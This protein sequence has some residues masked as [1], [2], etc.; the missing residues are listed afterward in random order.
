MI[1]SRS[2]RLLATLVVG[3]AVLLAGC[4]SS[5]PEATDSQANKHLTLLYH[6]KSGT[7]DPHNDWVALRA[8]VVE[9]L[10]RLDDQ[11]Q[12]KPWLATEWSTT[13]NI[14]WT[15]TIRDNITFQDGTKLDAA[16]VK[17]SFE[18]GIRVSKT[19]ANS[20]KI[21]SLEANGQQLTLV[22]TQPHPSLPSELVNPYAAVV[23]VAAEQ[24]MGS[25]AFNQAP[26]GT[27]PFQVT[28]FAPNA[29]IALKRYDNY[30]D[31]AAKL[32]TLTFKFNE[33]G[34]VRALG[35]QT[36]EADIATQLPPE[37]I[38]PIQADPALKIES[39]PSLRVHFLLFNHQKPSMQDINV[40]RAINALL[41][42]E[43]IAKDVML[44]NATPA[45]GPFS[46]RLPFS[47]KDAVP[48]LNLNE[49][50]QRLT[51]AGY[52][53]GADGKWVKN[54]QP[55]TLELIT[56]K[57]RPE[58]PLIA[59]L[60][61]SDAAKIGLTLNIKTVENVDTYLR[62]NRDWDLVTYSNLAAPRGDGGYFLNSA[63]MPGG[64]L[65]AA[66][67]TSPQLSE[68]VQRLNATSDLA[69]RV[70]VTQEAV[71]V[72]KEEVPHAY[73]VYPNLIIGV[74][75]RITNWQPGSEEYYIITNKLDVK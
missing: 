74:N 2:T 59:Q 55:L 3:T 70:A 23:S 41:N 35:L 33:D 40:R 8:G 14:R 25:D 68:V 47:S 16:A 72:I 43:S 10:V 37:S 24:K 38:A 50:K 73:T 52:E 51:A 29:E 5:A 67:F 75:K 53:A 30:W 6:F 18:R 66:N 45:N 26:V 7:L 57:G 1:K 36:K 20:L 49:A 34:N 13:D 48:A 21:A 54:G 27:G 11:L 19:L 64:A 63:L 44:G 9:T 62:E 15:F 65:N 56:Y 22:T 69:Q 46:T 32:D 58:L 42:R 31:G 61:Q 71:R 4:S 60:L 17:A 39:I 28:K 12:L